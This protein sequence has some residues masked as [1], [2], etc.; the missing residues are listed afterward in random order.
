MRKLL[1]LALFLCVHWAARG[2]ATFDYKYWFDGNDSQAQLLTSANAHWQEEID[3]SQLDCMLHSFHFQAKNE[4][5][6]WSA[7][8]TAYFIKTP[9]QAEGQLY[10][11]LDDNDKTEQAFSGGNTVAMIDVSKLTDGLHTLHFYYKDKSKTNV[12]STRSCLF[13]KLPMTAKLGN[14][15]LWVDND[16]STLQRGK[17]NGQPLTFDASALSE[18]VHLLHTQVGND[19]YSSPSSQMFI[20]VPQTEGIDSLTCMLFVDGELYKQ[21]AVATRNGLLHWELDA[22]GMTPGIH[23]LQVLTVTPSGAAT[24]MRETYFYRTMTPQEYASMKCYYSVDGSSHQN[25][26]G[27][28]KNGLFHFDLDLSTLA[29]GLHQISFMMVTENGIT[30]K[31]SSAF[32]MKTPIGGNGITRYDYWLNDN[33]E[34]AVRTDLSQRVDPLKLMQLLPVTSEPFRSSSFTFEVD[35]A[36]VPML[37]A[38]ND[39]HLRTFDAAGRITESSAAFTDYKV[40]REVTDVETIT[41]KLG[42]IVSDKPEANGILWFKLEAHIGDSLAVRN[43]QAATLQ[44][45]SPSGK[46]VY[47]ADGA[48]SMQ[49][50][51]FH[52]LEEGTYWIA[53]HD[54][55]A[56]YGRTINLDYQH[57][58]QFA[59][60]SYTPD[61]VGV[62]PG[63]FNMKLFGNGYDFLKKA[64]LKRG[65][66]SIEASDI[67]VANYSEAELMFILENKE[68]ERGKYNLELTFS[69]DGQEEI[70]VVENALAMQ[71]PNYGNIEVSIEHTP[72]MAALC[73]VKIKVKNTG[74]VNQLFVPVNFAYDNSKSITKLRFDNFTVLEPKDYVDMGLKIESVTSNLFNKQLDGRAFHLLVPNIGPNEEVELDLA[75]EAPGHT[76]F[77]M[78][79]WTG[80]PWSMVTEY[81]GM[82]K[83]RIQA[84]VSSF[85]TD[86]MPD[87]CEMLGLVADNSECPCGLL[88]ANATALANLYASLQRYVNMEAIRA[89]G[90]NSYEEARDA[91][92]IDMDFMFRRRLICPNSILARLLEHCSP[93]QIQTA[94]DFM[95]SMQDEDSESDCPRPKKKRIETL[96]PGDPND[97]FGYQSEAESPFVKKG[98]TDIF[99]NIEFE[100][101]PEIATAAAHTIVVTDLLNP[102]Y[103]DLSSYEPTSIKIGHVVTP[104]TG[105][106]NFVKTIDLRPSI[107]VIAQVNATYDAVKG[108]ATWTITSLDPMTMEPTDNPMSGVLPV[109]VDGNGIG[110]I[111]FNIKLKASLENGTEIPNQASIV[112]DR[113][114][115]ILTPIWTNTLDHIA[116]TSTIEK[117][118]LQENGTDIELQ[119]KGEDDRSGIWCY[120]IYARHEVDGEWLKVGDHVTDNVFTFKGSKGFIYEFCAVAYDKAG[121]MEDK[122]IKS[123]NSMSTLLVGDANNDGKVNALDASLAT[124]YFLGQKVELNFAAADVNQ[125]GKINALDVSLIHN[126][127]LSQTEGKVKHV[128]RRL[129]T[130]K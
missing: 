127:Y 41:D 112:F 78:Y 122:E 21:E 31:A 29:D 17:F 69:K 119:M 53:Q 47:N 45:F 24:G 33:E 118:T 117:C 59:T 84:C 73:P 66:Q 15:E 43:S 130:N 57:I 76:K 103:F 83:Q 98:L 124:S 79:A 126:I 61:H 121:N 49:Y 81:E 26:A 100:N 14:Y 55:T 106:K 51:G 27:V 40:S 54:V 12:S 22:A 9:N 35:K 68:Y 74:N 63:A 16:R 18:G 92:G 13:Y 88:L 113:E 102:K 52:A 89:A 34:N 67:A 108:L 28:Y 37:Y 62:V 120:D 82:S 64:V 23:K 110:E 129:K 128:R 3:V 48:E 56:T 94:I 104:L 60:L 111:S 8:H 71:E 30:S 38:R 10:Y 44:V 32:F 11:W 72:T 39:F 93:S 36:G 97:I 75:F 99:Y 125:D 1:L 19:A 7:P 87:P 90:Y 65:D 105:E 2:Q 115:A 25:E 20:K 123:E 91:L 46:E 101:D 42:S 85:S 95:N 114:D 4:K 109:N 70:L 96:T 5:G 58:N 77:N 107:N 50:G 116:P 6:V 80:K 86:C